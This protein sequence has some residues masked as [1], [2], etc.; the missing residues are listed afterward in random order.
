[1]GTSAVVA[2]SHLL[3]VYV[4]EFKVVVEEVA[5]GV[6]ASPEAISNGLGREKLTDGL[7]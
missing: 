4:Y 5:A 6:R 2:L 7:R 3:R 1:M